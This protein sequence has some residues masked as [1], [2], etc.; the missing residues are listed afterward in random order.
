M[1]RHVIPIGRI[2]GISIDLDYSWFLI[3]GLLTW[4]LA[5]SYYPIEFRNWSTGEYWL[6]GF[7]T[8]VLLFVSVLIHEVGHSVI[9]KRYGLA[10]P[11]ITLF[12]FGGV[13]QLAAEP[14]SASAEFWIAIVGPLLSFALAAFFWK[15]EPLVT[16]FQPLFAVVKYL[17][18][19][20]LILAI[21]NLIPGFP[22]DGGRIL[23]AI[24][25]QITGRYRRATN[26]AALTGRFF[27]FLLIFIGVW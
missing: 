13:S 15:M 8:A 25:W 4:M 7:V 16:S 6:T 9:A 5:V 10:V 19:L 23:R 21:F 12:L 20:N 11:R 1:F 2:F 17:A 24:L 22:L 14:A 18:L 26:V 27:G 3:V